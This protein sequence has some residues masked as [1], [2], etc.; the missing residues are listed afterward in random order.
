MS[1]DWSRS[2]RYQ[3]VAERF[4]SKAMVASYSGILRE[5]RRKGKFVVL[6]NPFSQ[7]EKVVRRRRAG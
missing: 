2:L 1:D 5:M 7:R 3:I 6:F 4:S